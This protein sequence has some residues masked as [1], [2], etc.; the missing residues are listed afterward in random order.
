LALAIVCVAQP[1]GGLEAAII[2]IIT[3]YAC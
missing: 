1:C 3:C 2:T